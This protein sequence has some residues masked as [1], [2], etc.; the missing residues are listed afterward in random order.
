ML[1]R[2]SVTHDRWQKSLIRR[3]GRRLGTLALAALACAAGWGLA[4]TRSERKVA[5]VADSQVELWTIPAVSAP[6]Q[7]AL[8]AAF[9]A[10]KTGHLAAADQKFS[11]LLKQQRLWTILNSDRA[12][13]ALAQHNEAKF[14]VLVEQGE[15][16]GSLNA[17]DGKLLLALQMTKPGTF[18]TAG[19]LF[20]E[21]AAADPTRSDIFDQWGDCLLRWG[22]PADAAEKFRGALLR[23][24]FPVMDDLYQTKVVLAQIQSGQDSPAG[25]GQ[26]LDTALADPE[27]ST[28][29]LFAGAARAMR[30]NQFAAAASFL[31]RARKVTAPSMYLALL[32]NPCFSGDSW[33]PELAP[34]YDAAE[35]AKA[36]AL[37]LLNGE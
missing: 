14:Q 12:C 19:G 11:D 17:A 5:P 23:N 7:R 10:L 29:A 36:D 31:E 1:Q 25:L 28:A 34:L 9:A 8:D 21:A 13:V 22:K 16:D 2:L 33:R 35:K 20:A 4:R 30:T 32:L 15:K 26:R 6:Q 27:P 24:P 37:R 18:Q 3:W